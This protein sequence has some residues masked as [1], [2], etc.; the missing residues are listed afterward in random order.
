[1][2]DDNTKS[3]SGG[4]DD[5]LEAK[6]GPATDPYKDL[7]EGDADEIADWMAFT[8]G[9]LH[10]DVQEEPTPVDAE[11]ADSDDEGVSTDEIVTPDE[12]PDELS[13]GEIDDDA[14]SVG[15]VHHL[16]TKLA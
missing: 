4:F 6:P 5:W 2:T 11:G 13:R 14:K 1:M 16:L 8:E 12:A 10:S 9:T 15:L 3:G 7:A